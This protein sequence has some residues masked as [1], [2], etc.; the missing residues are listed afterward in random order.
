MATSPARALALALLVL[1]CSVRGETAEPAERG[2]L[3]TADELSVPESSRPVKDLV[4]SAG[5]GT[6][7]LAE[8]HAAIVTGPDGA[9]AGLFL[10]GKGTF[11]YLSRDPREH[12][13]VRWVLSK[14]TR[15]SPSTTDA[16][17]AV[18]LPLVLLAITTTGFATWWGPGP[19]GVPTS[20]LLNLVLLAAVLRGLARART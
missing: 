7:R 20:S 10:E 5:A 15:L 1:P 6:V 8:G 16:G 11:A 19:L 4:L 13:A 2:V 9:L 3:R 14:N 17:L 12:P 18:A